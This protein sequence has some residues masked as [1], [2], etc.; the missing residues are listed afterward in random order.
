[1]VAT[2]LLIALSTLAYSSNILTFCDTDPVHPATGWFSSLGS[3][4]GFPPATQ[5]EFTDKYLRLGSWKMA[6]VLVLLSGYEGVAG[7]SS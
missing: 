4:H 3:R 6:G 7:E 1:M 5:G 2:Q